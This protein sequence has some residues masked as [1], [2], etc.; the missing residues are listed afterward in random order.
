MGSFLEK[1]CEFVFL[2]CG[3]FEFFNDYDVVWGFNCIVFSSLENREITDLV[4]PNQY[5]TP[6]LVLTD[7]HPSTSKVRDQA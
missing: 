2:F 4:A 3:I 1:Y 6:H 7:S 5:G